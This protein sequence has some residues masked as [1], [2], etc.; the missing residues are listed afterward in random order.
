[1]LFKAGW[2]FGLVML[3]S[4][5]TGACYFT[6]ANPLPKSPA[7]DKELLGWWKVQPDE[8]NNPQEQGYFLFL[9]DKDGYFQAVMV[10]N[11][12]QY[13]ELYRGFCSEINGQKYLNVKQ[14]SLGNE[15]A[16][17]SA[18]KNYSLIAYKITEGK[19]LEITLL[20]EDV[21]KQALSK[22]RLKG[23]LPK[24]EDDLVLSDTTENL[25][26]FFR[27]QAPGTLLDKPLSP[28]EKMTELPA[29]SGQ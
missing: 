23:T 1:M 25:A 13:D 7:M 21:F 18:D 19:R 10:D 17:P 11:L 4:L 5:G 3:L 8:K 20:N 6:S 26:R 24:K 12:Y 15:K 14:I 28:A 9:E 16:A 27:S 22:Q 2:K 29:P